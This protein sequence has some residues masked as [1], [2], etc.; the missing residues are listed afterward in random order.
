MC[1]LLSVPGRTIYR[2]NPPDLRRGLFLLNQLVSALRVCKSGAVA[3][4]VTLARQRSLAVPWAFDKTTT[5][6]ALRLYTAFTLLHTAPKGQ[7]DPR[8]IHAAS[9]VA[10]GWRGS[11]KHTIKYY[12]IL[13]V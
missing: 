2:V 13:H 8:E 4:H 5:A 7:A 12:R 11:T 10:W 3:T 9:T 6:V 1:W